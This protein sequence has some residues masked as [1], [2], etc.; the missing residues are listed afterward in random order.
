MWHESSFAREEGGGVFAVSNLNDKENKKA[1]KKKKEE[2]K[3]Q[4][5]E[6]RK[7]R[8]EFLRGSGMA[9]TS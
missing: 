7:R 5:G 2:M 4:E 8:G 9:W 1:S 3:E 6:Q